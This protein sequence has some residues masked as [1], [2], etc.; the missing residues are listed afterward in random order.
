MLK[1]CAR[2]VTGLV[3]LAA[4]VGGAAQTPLPA[5]SPKDIDALFKRYDSKTTP[6]CS[7]AV[8]QSGKVAFL[9]SYGM[10]DPA[11][12]VPMKSS[13]SSWIPYS[14]ARVF[15]AVGVAMLARDG[16]ISLDG[17]VRKHVPQVPAYASMVT[18]RQ[19]LR[20]E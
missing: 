9:K 13:T 5:P 11:L 17:P 8:I 6:G 7:V 16:K 19:L 1:L 20:S 4:G 12:G 2:A 15:L 18:I 10:A 3:L 14:E